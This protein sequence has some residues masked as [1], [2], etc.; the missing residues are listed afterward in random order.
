V[1]IAVIGGGLVGAASVHALLDEGHAVDW[2]DRAGLAAGASAGNAGWIAHM[3]ILPL[4]SPKVWR[5]MPRWLLDPLGP[6]S[7]RPAY[8]PKLAPFLARFVAA[9][10]GERIEASTRAI[11]ALN[12]LSLPAWERRLAALGLGGHLRRKGI[13]SVWPSPA[14]A[15]A[16]KALL[17]RQKSLGIDVDWLDRDALVALEPALGPKAAKGA[18]YGGG[19]H[20]SDPKALTLDLGRVAIERGARLLTMEVVAVKPQADAVALVTGMDSLAL[21]DRVVIA[22]GAWS[23][24]LAASVGDAV[25]LDTER[26]YNVTLPAGQLGL[27]RPV[28]YEG[29][30]FVTTP[31]D[32]GDRIGG[33]VEFAGLEAPPNYARVDAILGRARRFLPDADLSGGTRWMGFRPSIPDS[34]PVISTASRDVRIV[35]AFGHGHYGLTQAAASA[36]IVADLIAGRA[37]SIDPA[38]YSVTRFARRF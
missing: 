4:A 9:S 38:P 35:H 18:L 7:I 33:S 15:D 17:A 24:P 26:G 34:L 10:R 8:L 12:G 22:A 2:L 6:L 30:G 27:T 5:Q 3:D 21:Y 25:P 28:M 16:A 1:R 36:E 14:E 11:T 23:K 37:P 32:S 29:Q 31:L 20:V 19:C 13:L